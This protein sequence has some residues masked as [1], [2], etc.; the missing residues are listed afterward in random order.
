LPPEVQK[1]VFSFLKRKTHYERRDLSECQMVCKNWTMRLVAIVDID[2]PSQCN[3]FV[4][5]I[6]NGRFVGYSAKEA[7]INFTPSDYNYFAK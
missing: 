7:N 1:L 2:Y 6:K 5:L 4:E 3:Q